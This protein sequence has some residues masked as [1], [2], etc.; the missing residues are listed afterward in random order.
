MPSRV[1]KR[2]VEQLERAIQ[3]RVE[4]PLVT[5]L[6]GPDCTADVG[7]SVAELLRERKRPPAT[8]RQARVHRHRDTRRSTIDVTA[9]RTAASSTDRVRFPCLGRMLM[10]ESNSMNLGVP[11]C[12]G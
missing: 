1:R 6:P 4:A 3:S 11:T 7:A 2:Q 5:F 10:T 9:A 8:A 12:A